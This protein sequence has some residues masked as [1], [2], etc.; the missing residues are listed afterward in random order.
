MKIQPDCI[1]CYVNQAKDAAAYA[2]MSEDELWKALKEVCRELSEVDRTKP[3]FQI[4]QKVHK[5]VR[6]ISRSRDPY[7]EQ[8]TKSNNEA[9]KYFNEFDRMVDN[10][11]DPLNRAARLATAGNAIDFGPRREFDVESALKE[12]LEEGFELDHWS[13]FVEQLGEAN[14]I[15]YFADNSGEIIYDGLFIEH[16]LE[17]VEKIVLVV[18]DGP[19]INDVTRQDGRDLG[20]EQVENVELKTVDNGDRGNQP[21]LWSAEVEGWIDDHDLVISKGQANYEGLSSHR[22]PNLFFLL[23]VKCPMVQRA[24]GAEVG[25]KVFIQSLNHSSATRTN[26]GGDPPQQS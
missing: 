20:L 5:I 6:D 9:L 22:K 11:Q 10:S 19:F 13:K 16:L 17:K 23:V 8:K 21:E 3:S 1:P 4:G 26:P 24:V 25:R 7:K 18:K 2:E 15:L 12:G 14:E